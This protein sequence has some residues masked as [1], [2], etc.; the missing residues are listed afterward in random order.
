VTYFS[1][2]DPSPMPTII[3][4][5][6]DPVQTPYVVPQPEEP[7]HFK[8]SVHK[9]GPAVD[10]DERS[11]DPDPDRVARVTDYT[12]TH[13]APHRPT[14]ATDTCLYTNTPDEDFVLDRQG[15][16]VIGSPCSGHGFKFTPLIGRI[17]A[18]LATGDRPPIPL[19]R[20]ASTRPTLA[21]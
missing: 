20:F 13:F 4:W 6:V 11:F 17:L 3:D 14:G 21:R 19:D 2:D 18:D 10:P 9:S 5:T 8:V 16:I 1:L 15:P 7:G 12:R